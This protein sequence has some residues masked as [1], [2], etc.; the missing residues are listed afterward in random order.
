MVIITENRKVITLLSVTIIS[1]FLL[2][3]YQSTLRS[4]FMYEH[5]DIGTQIRRLRTKKGL[6]Q[7]KFAELS[8]LSVNFISKLERGQMDNISITNI[9]K[10][11]NAMNISISE[12]VNDDPTQALMDFPKST[13]TLIQLLKDINPPDLDKLSTDLIPLIR[14]FR[15]LSQ[16]HYHAN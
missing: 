3:S 10:I 1:I 11:C 8:G 16:S 14:E 15:S 2:L 9:I 5:F 13:L 6:T 7:E 12:L 4:K